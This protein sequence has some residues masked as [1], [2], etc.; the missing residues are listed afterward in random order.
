ME[1][2]KGRGHPSFNFIGKSEHSYHF[3]ITGG[4]SRE[5][6]FNDIWELKVSVKDQS[7]TFSRIEFENQIDKLTGR[8]GHAGVYR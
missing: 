3:L 6:Q 2:P 4:A 7:Y 1:A 8:N 5:E